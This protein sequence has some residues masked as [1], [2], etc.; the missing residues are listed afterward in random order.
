MFHDTWGLIIFEEFYNETSTE[1]AQYCES[2]VKEWEIVVIYEFG[3]AEIKSYSKNG[4]VNCKP[5]VW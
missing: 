2:F 5:H 1:C 4:G 3:L